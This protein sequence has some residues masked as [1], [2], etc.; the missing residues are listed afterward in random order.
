MIKY[1]KNFNTGAHI[2]MNIDLCVEMGH[3]V[4]G[5]REGREGYKTLALFVLPCRPAPINHFKLKNET[6]AYINPRIL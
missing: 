1:F 3:G 6:M 4:G 2:D 5:Y